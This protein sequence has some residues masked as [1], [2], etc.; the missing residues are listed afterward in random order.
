MARNNQ[1]ESSTVDG[2][3]HGRVSRTSQACRCWRARP[4]QL[5]RTW[6]ASATLQRSPLDRPANGTGTTNRKLAVMKVANVALSSMKTNG[7]DVMCWLQRTW[8]DIVALQKTGLA[9][10]F[11]TKALWK[12][13]Y[14]SSFLGRRSAS[15]LGVGI[16]SRSN[17][18][19][20]KIRVC[21]LPGAEHA[22][23]R[24]LTVNVGKLQISS[25]YA[26]CPPPVS[27]TVDW[28]HRLRDHVRAERLGDRDS[29]L[30]GD[31]NVYADGPPMNGQGRKALGELRS[32][33]LVDLY[34]EAHPDPIE[35]PG[36]T[37]GY[38]RQCPQ[39][40]SR[41]HLILASRSL[42]RRMQSA[43]VNVNSRPW[44]RKDSPPLVVEMDGDYS[45]SD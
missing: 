30:C 17:L 21:Q 32:L 1:P 34:R 40:T 25:L 42:R 13:G 10:D 39:G 38:S 29:L 44:P 19:S 15:D 37:L 24:F 22:E 43:C 12:L 31:F 9:K 4:R 35:C 18:P 2:T 23:S 16:L 26:P 7:P 14:R 41:L 45:A 6:K 28:I 8:P 11:P 27:L 33:G 3:R 36:C 5:T 20:P